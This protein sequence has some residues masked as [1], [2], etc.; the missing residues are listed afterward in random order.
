MVHGNKLESE[1]NR[2]LKGCPFIYI[3]LITL[4]FGHLYV[5]FSIWVLET[6]TSHLII[7]GDTH[8]MNVVLAWLS[9]GTCSFLFSSTAYWR[10]ILTEVDSA[11]WMKD[12]ALCQRRWKLSKQ[13]PCM[14]SD[15][16]Q[17]PFSL[18]ICCFPCY[19]C[20]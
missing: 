19:Q 18:L 6:V 5:S 3:T 9:S 20:N 16:L 12:I 7:R 14:S 2:E 4:L 8:D 10:W 15:I 11:Y 13:L 17:V 1:T